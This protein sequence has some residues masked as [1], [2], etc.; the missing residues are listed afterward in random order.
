M[1]CPADGRT[2][3]ILQKYEEDRKF[4]KN[5]KFDKNGPLGRFFVKFGVSWVGR[6]HVT[7][8]IKHFAETKCP[9]HDGGRWVRCR[10]TALPRMPVRVLSKRKAAL[11]CF[12]RLAEAKRKPEDG[13]NHKKVGTGGGASAFYNGGR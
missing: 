6:M 12:V 1:L 10:S 4:A 13:T 3:S 5:T 9:R 7:P 11:L 2:N 8:S